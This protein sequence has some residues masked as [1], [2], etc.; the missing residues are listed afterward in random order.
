M[1]KRHLHRSF[2]I[3]G[4]VMKQEVQITDTWRENKWNTI[5]KIA[6]RSA[7]AELKK[8]CAKF[9]PNKIEKQEVY[10]V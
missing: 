6:K 8:L 5:R 1:L 3:R 4:L 7:D 10:H 2:A 9:L